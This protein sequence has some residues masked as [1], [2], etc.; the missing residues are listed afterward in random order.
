[1][2]LHGP[3]RTDQNPWPTGDT[4]TDQH[5]YNVC[6]VGEGLKVQIGSTLNG[7]T[8]SRKKQEK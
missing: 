7:L 4:Y 6:G 8:L 3:G 2:S 5:G 1:M